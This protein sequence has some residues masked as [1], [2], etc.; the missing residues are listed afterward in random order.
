MQ[1]LKIQ[2][3]ISRAYFKS[4]PLCL[5]QQSTS[6]FMGPYIFHDINKLHEAPQSWSS[7][8]LI[9]QNVIL[10]PFPPMKQP[11]EQRTLT[12]SCYCR[13]G[14]KEGPTVVPLAQASGVSL[15]GYAT[16]VGLDDILQRDKS[17][18]SHNPPYGKFMCLGFPVLIGNIKLQ[19]LLALNYNQF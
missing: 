3:L 9:V 5:H 7:V 4:L 6:R 2:Q 16:L 13:D 14:E 8:C 10:A 12:N 11:C 1:A 17:M 19:L 15:E 18:R